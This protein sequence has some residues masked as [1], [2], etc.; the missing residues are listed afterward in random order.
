MKPGDGHLLAVRVA[1]EQQRDQRDDQDDQG[2]FLRDGPSKI[3]GSKV[4]PTVS[5]T[6]RSASY[7]RNGAG[8]TRRQALA[9][10]RARRGDSMGASNRTP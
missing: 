2:V 10:T 4:D 1:K 8:A 5:C 3:H 9:L 7:G 6:G